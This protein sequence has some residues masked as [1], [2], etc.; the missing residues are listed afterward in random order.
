MIQG[1]LELPGYTLPEMVERSIALLREHEPPDGYY[2][3][4]SGGK[5][6]VVI[7]ELARLAGVRVVWHYNVTTIDP[8]E[9]VRFIK[10]EHPDVV[11]NRSK[12]GNFFKRME[13]KGFPT[14]RARWCCAE[15]K[16]ALPPKG[17]VLI[18]GIRAEESAARAKRWGFVTRHT[19]TGANAVLPILDWP[20]EELWQFIH[21]QG[22]PYCE[23]YNEGFHRLGCV[24]CPMAGRKGREKEF[25]RW[26]GFERRWKLAFRRIWERRN[27][28]RQRDGRAWFG[29][30][31][32]RDWEHMWEWWLSDDSLPAPLDDDGLF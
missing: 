27:G 30:A 17:A 10:R 3:C 22:V 11:W 20:S 6:S 25:A 32:F 5:D 15:Y 24:G 12:H 29:V 21:G 16:E 26:P 28:T 7:K 31:R 1:T 19:R 9:L 13:R 23:L 4:F 2:G 8:P 18:L 14:R